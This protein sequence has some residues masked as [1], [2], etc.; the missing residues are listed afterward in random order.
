MSDYKITYLN[1]DYATIY[2]NGTWDLKDATGRI[3]TSWWFTSDPPQR[4]KDYLDERQK[5]I[6]FIGQ[7][8]MSSSDQDAA[9]VALRQYLTIGG[10]HFSQH[11]LNRISSGELGPD[12]RAAYVL[13]GL[14]D[15]KPVPGYGTP[16]PANVA[17]LVTQNNMKYVLIAA[18]AAAVAFYVFKKV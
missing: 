6:Q 9:M 18:A 14:V 16:E 12:V 17:S 11:Y 13:A 8:Q 7:I 1:G 2:A 10:N 4:V 3:I 5:Q 15:G